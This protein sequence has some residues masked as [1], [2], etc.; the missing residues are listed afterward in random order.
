MG[1]GKLKDR[2]QIMAEAQRNPIKHISHWVKGEV[3]SLE[4]LIYAIGQRDAM[5]RAKQ[6]ALTDCSE[7]QDTIDKLNAGKFT[8]G[9]VFK[10]E[11]A[12]KESAIT[13][14]ALKLQ[15]EEDIIN[16]DILKRFLSI[17]FATIA[18][19]DIKS[20][21]VKNYVQAMAKMCGD[22]VSNASSLTECWSNFQDLIVQL[23]IK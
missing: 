20:T 22:E 15:L 7:A 21:K 8:F 13:K 11:S 9:S 12:K 16:Y 3:L 1:Q 17:Y 10:S 14:A 6:K 4:A 5:D 19:P 2:L 18:I 23:N